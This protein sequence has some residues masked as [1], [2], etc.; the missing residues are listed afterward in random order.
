MI[1]PFIS[2]D[3]MVMDTKNHSFHLLNINSLI[4][5]FIFMLYINHQSVYSVNYPFMIKS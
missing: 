5:P 2:M 3:S 4:Q 1:Q